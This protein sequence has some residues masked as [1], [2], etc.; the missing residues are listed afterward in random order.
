MTAQDRVAMSLG[1]LLG[2]LAA[3]VIRGC[4]GGM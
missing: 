2:L 3:V 4:N 1:L